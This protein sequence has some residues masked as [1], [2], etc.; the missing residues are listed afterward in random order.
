MSP[1]ICSD[2]TVAPNREKKTVLNWMVKRLK[3]GIPLKG[4]VAPTVRQFP[5]LFAASDKENIVNAMR[6]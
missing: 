5:L 4:L 1:T 6:W 2:T 3:S